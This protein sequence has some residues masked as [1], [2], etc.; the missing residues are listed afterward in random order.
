M[1]LAPIFTYK[2][3]FFIYRDIMD[4]YDTI[5][6]NQDTS[7]QDLSDWGSCYYA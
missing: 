1:H 6:R 7:D 3:V 4:N 5:R 2:K